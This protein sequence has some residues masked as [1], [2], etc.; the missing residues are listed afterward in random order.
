MPS[1]ILVEVGVRY[2]EGFGR[3]LGTRT[4]PERERFLETMNSGD[5]PRVFGYLRILRA[6]EP[7][8]RVRTCNDHNLGT[9]RGVEHLVPTIGVL[10][11]IAS[12]EADIERS[13]FD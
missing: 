13:P 2:T 5:P 10:V 11:Y 9:P 12:E 6:E 7:S 4:Q 1:N 8:V 3:Y